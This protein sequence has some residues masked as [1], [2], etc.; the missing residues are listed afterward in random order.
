M[1]EA[2]FLGNALKHL[3]TKFSKPV[4]KMTFQYISIKIISLM[5]NQIL[6]FISKRGQSLKPTGEI[7]SK[8]ILWITRSD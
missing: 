3:S 8:N 4:L 1:T 6:I 2:D 5:Q 7:L